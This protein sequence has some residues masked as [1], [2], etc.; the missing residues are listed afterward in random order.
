MNFQPNVPQLAATNSGQAVAEQL[1]NTLDTAKNALKNT[2]SEFSTQAS[3]GVGATSEFLTTNTIIAKFAF[4]L[5]LLILFLVLFNLG[6]AIIGYFTEPSTDPYIVNGLINGNVAKVAPQDPKQSN[7][8][9][10]FRSNN[11]SKGMEFTW[12][13]WLYLNDLGIDNKYQHIFSKGDGNISTDT[14]LSTVNNGPGL[15]L[16][17]MSNTLHVVMDTVSASDRHTSIDIDNLPIKK[18]FHVALRL[19]N[20]VLDVYVNGIVVNRL[21]LNNTPKQNYGNVYVCQNGG[22]NGQLSNL[23]YYSRALNVFEINNIVSSGP[24]MKVSSDVKPM[25][26]YSYLS[27]IWYASKF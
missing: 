21:I 1:G 9:P 16:K 8:I 3:A 14:N 10:I 17:P 4:I 15:Y 2:F 22:F 13:T 24:N 7:A 11:Q 5:L 19:Q 26:G 25:T 20:T 12:S 23:R 18:W 6:L 27:N